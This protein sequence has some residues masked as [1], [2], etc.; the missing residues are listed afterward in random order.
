[1]PHTG[2]LHVVVANEPGSLG[3][4]ST[5]IGKNHGNISNLKI[6]N[7]SLDFFEMLL[8]VEVHDL[9]HLNDII[10]A[11]RA[12]PVITSVERAKH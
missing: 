7:R 9:K 11:L 6:T 3:N 8:D 2:R 12:T 4:L 1:E 5:V 10:A